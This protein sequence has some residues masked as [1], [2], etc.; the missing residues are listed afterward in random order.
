MIVGANNIPK[1]RESL[2]YPLYLD[3]IRE[4]IAKMLKFLIGGRGWDKQTLPISRKEST[5]VVS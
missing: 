3:F 4:G 5:M 1:S 2:F